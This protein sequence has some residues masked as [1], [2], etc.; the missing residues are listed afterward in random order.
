MLPQI[1]DHSFFLNFRYPIPEIDE[2]D[3]AANESRELDN[4]EDERLDDEEEPNAD[5][6]K[7]DDDDNF[8]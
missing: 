3:Q 1:N 2:A 7:L 4:E 6:L 8:I 5:D